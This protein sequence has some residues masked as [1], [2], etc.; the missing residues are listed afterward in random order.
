MLWLALALAAQ[1]Q[2]RVAQQECQLARSNV[3]YYVLDIP[4]QAL[5]LKL[6][7]LE[8]ASYPLKSIEV[9]VSLWG[10]ADPDW[11]EKVYDLEPRPIPER[12]EIQPSTEGQPP[13]SEPL[14]T[15]EQ[16][17]SSFTMNAGRHLSLRVTSDSGG[18][19]LWTA[20]ADRLASRPERGAVR[21]RLTLATEDAKALHRSWP[22]KSKLLIVPPS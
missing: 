10:A 7:A 11:M 12:V 15:L 16:A 14:T 13:A 5:R 6:R 20:L 17:P 19:K 9:G 22:L 4:Q 1:A 8:L 18:F 21:L 2:V 3:H